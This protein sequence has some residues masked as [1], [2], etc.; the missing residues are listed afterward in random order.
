MPQFQG[1]NLQ[2][3]PRRKTS[4]VSGKEPGTPELESL[5]CAPAPGRLGGEPGL[6]GPEV[7]TRPSKS[8]LQGDGTQASGGKLLLQSCQSGGCLEKEPVSPQETATQLL[9]ISCQ[10]HAER[11]S[12]AGGSNPRSE[13]SPCSEFC[14]VCASTLKNPSTRQAVRHSY[15]T[16]E[17]WSK[18][19]GPRS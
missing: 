15:C 13:V 10:I 9:L 7:R 5:S 16:K 4:R 1:G 17:I 6:A 12:R 8:K 11:D 2:H 3:I 14:D 18:R 19:A